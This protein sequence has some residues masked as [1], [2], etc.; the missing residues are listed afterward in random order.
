MTS[1]TGFHPE[2][3]LNNCYCTNNRFSS[4]VTITI[5]AHQWAFHR[6]P[7]YKRFGSER[8]YAPLDPPQ[9]FPPLPNAFIKIACVQ[10]IT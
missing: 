4:W 9:A 5:H 6:P 2:H 8:A 10:R 3:L 7:A 1:R